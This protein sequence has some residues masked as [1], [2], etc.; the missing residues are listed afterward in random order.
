MTSNAS[1]SASGL[2]GHPT[3]PPMHRETGVDELADGLGAVLRERGLVDAAVVDRAQRATRPTGERF[4]RVLTKLGLVAE[5][6][7]AAALSQYLSIPLAAPGDV[8]PEPL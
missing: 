4:D 6:D 2:N 3:V 7:L 1:L 5:T 8:P